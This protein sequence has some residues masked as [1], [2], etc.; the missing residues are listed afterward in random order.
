MASEFIA[1]VFLENTQICIDPLQ[2]SNE[3]VP[4]QTTKVET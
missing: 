2:N 4:P 3:N 1:N